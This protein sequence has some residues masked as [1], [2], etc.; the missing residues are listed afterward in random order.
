MTDH[1]YPDI[2]LSNLSPI[3]RKGL[4]MDI[5]QSSRK[6]VTM[7]DILGHKFNQVQ[8]PSVKKTI[9]G[10]FLEAAD[11]VLTAFEF[12]R[13]GILTEKVTVGPDGRIE[14]AYSIR[15]NRKQKWN[16]TYQKLK[17]KALEASYQHDNT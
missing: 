8:H 16:Q 10:C 7:D 4:M 13:S 12:V 5:I 1:L 11:V 6:Q 14:R 9:R 15:Q 2:S 17:T 3:V